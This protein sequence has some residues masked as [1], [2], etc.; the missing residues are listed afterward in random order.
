MRVLSAAAPEEFCATARAL[1][2]AAMDV[3]ELTCSPSDVRRAV[4]TPKPSSVSCHVSLP[5]ALLEAE[6]QKLSGQRIPDDPRNPADPG[7]RKATPGTVTKLKQTV[8]NQKAEIQELRQL[9]TRL[10][11]ADAVLTQASDRPAEHGP[12]S[13][14]IVPFPKTTT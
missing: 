12:T 11:L 13:D 1:D 4:M 14:N 10:T 7:I 8:A 5:G 9:V 6:A 2:L 3:V